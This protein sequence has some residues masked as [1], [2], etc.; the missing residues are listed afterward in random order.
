MQKP[1]CGELAINGD[2]ACAQGDIATLVSLVEV[3][4]ERV[5]EPFHRELVAIAEGWLRDPARA[6]IEWPNLRERV[7]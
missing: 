4:A 3:I 5:D 2:R 7:F 1:T 6:G